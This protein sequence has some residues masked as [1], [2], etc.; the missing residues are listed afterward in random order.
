VNAR[1]REASARV[2]LPPSSTSIDAPQSQTTAERWNA[3][4]EHLAERLHDDR[5]S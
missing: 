3:L 2:S 4:L 1:L 5:P